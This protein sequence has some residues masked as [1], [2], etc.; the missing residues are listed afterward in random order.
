MS[1][2]VT[3][4]VAPV[5]RRPVRADGD[6]VPLKDLHLVQNFMRREARNC[7]PGFVRVRDESER[8]WENR[9]TAL[10]GDKYSGVQSVFSASKFVTVGP[11]VARYPDRVGSW[12]HIRARPTH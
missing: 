5:A 6:V 11:T 12:R 1:W 3:S 4:R 9:S 7:L 2:L 10:Q 8:R